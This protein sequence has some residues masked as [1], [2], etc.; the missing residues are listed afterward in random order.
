MS[1]FSS[2]WSASLLATMY[3]ILVAFTEG[4]LRM[5]ADYSAAP[6]HHRQSF[7]GRVPA[8][9][10]ALSASDEDGDASNDNDVPD[11]PEKSQMYNFISNYLSKENAAAKEEESDDD[12]STAEDDDDDSSYSHLIALPV[13]AC[14]ELM[15]ELE[16]VQRAV[17]YNC[18]L[19]VHACITQAITRLP[20]LYVQTDAD[21]FTRASTVLRDMTQDVVT[22]HMFVTESQRKEDAK[23]AEEESTDAEMKEV[24]IKKDD[25]MPDLSGANADDIKPLMMTFQSLEID[26]ARNEVLHSVA[27]VTDECTVR[28]QQMVDDLRERIHRETGWKTALPHDDHAGTGV[29]RPRIPFMRL[30]PNWETILEN[31]SDFGEEKQDI[32][33]LNSD[34]GGNGI[35]PILWCQWMEDVF[36]TARMREVAVY[37]RRQSYDLLD[38]QAFYLPEK[39]VLLPEG[40]AALAKAEAGHRQYHEERMAEAEALENKER[41]ASSQKSEPISDDDPL[42]VKTRD[43]LEALYQS[44]GA[45]ETKTVPT[46]EQEAVDVGYSE[47]AVEVDVDPASELP[48]DPETLDDWTKQRIQK[49]IA[50]RARVQSQEELAKPKEKPSIEENPIFNK[51]KEGTLVSE[52]EKIAYTEDSLPPFPSREHCTGFWRVVSSPTGFDVEEG[53]SSRSDNLVCRVDG[54]IAGG[55]ILDQETRQKASGGT[56]KVSGDTDDSAE[57]RIRLVIPPDKKRILVMEGKLKRVSLKS[58]LPM[59]SSTFGI[60][61]LEEKAAQA[62]EETEEILF[63]GGNVFIEDA[64]TGNNREEIGKFSLQKLHT[65]T[66]PTQYT[67]TVPRPVRNQD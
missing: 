60:P 11:G 47:E 17:L 54:T 25:G 3:L 10:T 40:N 50:S 5:P 27:D 52:A 33:L 20:L 62:A 36:A 28:L 1:L 22:K 7:T 19:L 15:L 44:S 8:S 61:Q 30:P 56:W 31:E 57:L 64:V 32:F 41:T 9:I 49:A 14:H 59:A 42:L 16:S 53:D 18:P 24:E 35:S 55:P 2:S 66:D 58:D 43:R 51:Y 12:V 6:R 37:K 26:G 45:E 34:Q 63:C 21:S 13:D 48:V 29:F 65:P 67:I 38:E 46:T 23:K 4:F 39:N